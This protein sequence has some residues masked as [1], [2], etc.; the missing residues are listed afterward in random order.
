[1][2]GGTGGEIVEHED[3]AERIAGIVF[4]TVMIAI[5]IVGLIGCVFCGIWLVREIA[6]M[7]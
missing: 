3:F 5:A 4:L 1:V 6:G 7:L 2:A